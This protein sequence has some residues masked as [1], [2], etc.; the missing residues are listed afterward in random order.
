[1]N[2]SVCLRL[3]I[4]ICGYLESSFF[5]LF[6]LSFRLSS[7]ITSATKQVLS[8]QLQVTSF[9][10][11]LWNTLC[12]HTKNTF[13]ML[14]FIVIYTNFP[15][16]QQ[17]P[18]YIIGTRE[19]SIKQIVK[20][21]KLVSNWWQIGR[22]R[23]VILIFLRNDEISINY[24]LCFLNYTLTYIQFQNFLRNILLIEYLLKG[25]YKNKDTTS[26]FI[27]IVVHISILFLQNT[28]GFGDK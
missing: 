14:P 25:R 23:E 10:F 11:K 15:P 2:C 8:L 17:S 7:D 5:D 9:F 26:K 12:Q 18:L 4:Y 6:Y 27:F 24:P 22:K 28:L 19:I 3:G 20:S 21:D 13:Y 1:M 16:F